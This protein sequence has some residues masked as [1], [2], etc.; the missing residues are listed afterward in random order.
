[1]TAN[2]REKP[3]RPPSGGNCAANLLSHEQPRALWARSGVQGTGTVRGLPNNGQRP[4]KTYQT[5]E[6]RGLSPS[7][8][9]CAANLLSHE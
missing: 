5:G 7:G 2:D 9:N 4:R 1:M 3:T 8:G 6:P